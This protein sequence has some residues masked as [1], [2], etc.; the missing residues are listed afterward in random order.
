VAVVKKQAETNS[1]ANT[2]TQDSNHGDVDMRLTT[3]S[4]SIQSVVTTPNKKVPTTATTTTAATAQVTTSAP[5]TTVYKTRCRDFDGKYFSH[6][7]YCIFCSNSETNF[8]NNQ[9]CLFS[10]QGYCMRGDLCQFDHGADPVVVDN[11][12]GLAYTPQG[13]AVAPPA[14]HRGAAST[15]FVPIRPAQGH[16]GIIT[17]QP[18]IPLATA[19]ASAGEDLSKSEA[20]DCTFAMT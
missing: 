17:E 11:M 5:T 3:S 13:M 7:I 9:K 20:F 18:A 16:G 12:P 2:P 4:Q 19:L 1:G 8:C 14:T 15:S 10:E 6:L